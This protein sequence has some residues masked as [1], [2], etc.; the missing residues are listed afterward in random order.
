MTDLNAVIERI[1]DTIDDAAKHYGEHWDSALVQHSPGN[2]THAITNEQ[3]V[4]VRAEDDSL[5]S[6]WLCDYLEAVDPASVRVLLAAFSA[7]PIVARDLTEKEVQELTAIHQPDIIVSEPV[8]VVRHVNAGGA[9]RKGVHVSLYQQLPEGTEV[10]AAPPAPTPAVPDSAEIL[11]EIC[12]L[13]HIGEQARTRSAIMTN[14]QNTIGFAD[15]LRAVEQAFFMVPGEPDED[16]PDEEPADEC[17][18]NS[19]GSTVEQYVEQFRNALP[20]ITG[21]ATHERQ[22]R[23][24]VMMVKLLVRTVRKYNPGSQQAKDFTAYLQREGL[25]SASDC[26][27]DGSENTA[28]LTEEASV[29]ERLPIGKPVAW[30]CLRKGPGRF[31]VTLERVVAEEWARKGWPMRALCECN[32]HAAFFERSP[33]GAKD[34][35]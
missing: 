33:D 3:A 28:R 7:K 20:V 18:V 17:L 29:P 35:E 32:P 8:G 10:F 16:Y 6:S 31:V 1:T 15:Q 21:A 9:G 12:D 27:R 25:I 14:I 22:I 5:H 4:V 26:L 23:D 24:L 30:Q 11:N 19:W 13:F 2:N 34:P